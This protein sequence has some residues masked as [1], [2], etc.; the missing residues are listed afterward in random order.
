MLFS[1]IVWL[2]W[3]RWMFFSMFLRD[4]KCIITFEFAC[5]SDLHIDPVFSTPF[6]IYRYFGW[7]WMLCFCSLP[8]RNDETRKE[9][10]SLYVVL[11]WYDES[12]PS[13]FTFGIYEVHC[14]KEIVYCSKPT[15][16]TWNNVDS[17]LKHVG[18][19]IKLCLITNHVVLVFLLLKIS[20]WIQE[21]YALF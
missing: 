8:H 15:K 10:K 5:L 16:S 17:F 2:A 21:T 14:K 7:W 19:Q 13:R 12:S 4:L 6:L 20:L 11:T 18:E 1:F 9:V 3:R